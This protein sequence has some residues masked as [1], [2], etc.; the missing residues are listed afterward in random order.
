MPAGVVQLALVE[1]GGARLIL[2]RLR[3]AVRRRA[4]S[5]LVLGAS[6]VREVRAKRRRQLPGDLERIVLQLGA[7]V[8]AVQREQIDVGL[9]RCAPRP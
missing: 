9:P 3:S 2:R 7:I 4:A 5:E 6:E 1:I 8:G